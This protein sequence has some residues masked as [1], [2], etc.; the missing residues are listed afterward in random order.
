VVIQR[1]MGM[2]LTRIVGWMCLG[3]R[4]KKIVIGEGMDRVKSAAK[5]EIGCS[6][7]LYEYN[8]LENYRPETLH[9]NRSHKLEDKTETFKKQHLIYHIKN[10][11]NK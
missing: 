6:E 5:R 1:F 7:F 2:F 8:T 11:Q 3:L 4:C 10:L 9:T